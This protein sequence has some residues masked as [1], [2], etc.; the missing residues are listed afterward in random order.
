MPPRRAIAIAAA[1]LAVL[2]AVYFLKVWH[3]EGICAELGGVW[4]QDGFT[5]ECRFYEKNGRQ[6]APNKGL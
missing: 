2:V 4:E 1:G 6:S 5:G 3:A